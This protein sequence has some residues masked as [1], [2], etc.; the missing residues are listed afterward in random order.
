[1][2]GPYLNSQANGAHRPRRLWDMNDGA[3]A[4][5]FQAF[6]SKALWNVVIEGDKHGVLFPL[7]QTRN[8][9]AMPICVHAVQLKDCSRCHC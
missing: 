1:M 7:V 2:T 4:R 5:G 9:G 3:S 8:R 6:A